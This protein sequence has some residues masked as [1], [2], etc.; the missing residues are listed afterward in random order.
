MLNL[1]DMLY[2]RESMLCH[3]AVLIQCLLE[4]TAYMCHTVDKMHVGVSLEGR[5][6]ARKTV[7]L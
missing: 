4:V 2:L 1:I 5:L 6:I 3:R 7:T